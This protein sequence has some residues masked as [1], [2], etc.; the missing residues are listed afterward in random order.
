[1]P[2]EKANNTKMLRQPYYIKQVKQVVK[3][4]L[5]FHVGV[6]AVGTPH[7]TRIIAD[8]LVGFSELQLEG[9]AERVFGPAVHTAVGLR[10]RTQAE[11]AALQN[12]SEREETDG[13]DTHNKYNGVRE[14]APFV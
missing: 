11:L 3:I 14:L 10:A 1:M 4:K 8:R 6:V 2:T 7:G 9:G 5:T 13:C 12:V